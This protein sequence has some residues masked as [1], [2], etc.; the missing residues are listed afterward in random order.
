MRLSGVANVTQLHNTA[1]SGGTPGP[2]GSPQ[3]KANGWS[4]FPETTWCEK[5]RFCLKLAVGFLDVC[6]G[7]IQ[8]EHISLYFHSVMCSF[9]N[10]AF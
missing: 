2:G 1:Q 3:G 5:E 8:K 9:Q 6:V 7:V 10:L 4:H